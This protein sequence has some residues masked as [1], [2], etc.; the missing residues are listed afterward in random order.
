MEMN[1]NLLVEVL[2]D[3]FTLRHKFVMK[4][5]LLIKKV[6]SMTFIFDFDKRAFLGLG[7]SAVFHSMLCFFV[8]GLYW[9]TQVSFPVMICLRIFR[10]SLIFSSMSLQNLTWLG[11][12]SSDKILGTILA[13]TFC[14]PRSCS[15]IVC[16]DSLFTSVHLI[17]FALSTCNHFAPAASF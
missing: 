11:V 15:K 13:H 3:C 10:L 6:I 8:S 17:S 1:E 14:I 9:K 5:T 2:I 7:D 16:T 4:Y 12:W